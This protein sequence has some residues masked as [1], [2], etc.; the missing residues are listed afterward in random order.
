MPNFWF[1]VYVSRYLMEETGRVQALI[2]YPQLTGDQ[3]VI[4]ENLDRGD[5]LLA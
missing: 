1:I 3:K 4:Y 5:F 2:D